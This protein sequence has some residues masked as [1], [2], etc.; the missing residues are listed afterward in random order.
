MAKEI[1][2]EIIIHA[3][4]EKV[5]VILTD[6]ENYPN[7]NPFI[8]SVE[9]EE[10]NKITVKLTPPGGKTMTFKPTILTRQEN[11]KLKWLGTVLFK[12][13]FDGEHTFEL[14]ENKNGT[15]TFVQ[16]EQFK[17]IFAGLFNPEKTIN[18][19][20]EMNKKLKELAER[21]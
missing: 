13:L 20:N 4:A 3:R 15:V 9:P 2:T 5:W 12:G 21:E 11:Q 16:S 7:W 14:R 17:G 8:T 19:F 18:G 6:F 10:G 1:R